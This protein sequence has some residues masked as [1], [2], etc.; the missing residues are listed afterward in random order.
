VHAG[1][2]RAWLLLQHASLSLSTLHGPREPAPARP[3][4]PHPTRPT[5]RP[6]MC[7]CWSLQ[8]TSQNGARA[9]HLP[10]VFM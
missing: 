3:A 1:G 5:S 2:L 9:R 7:I 6:V 4:L 10:V 8:H